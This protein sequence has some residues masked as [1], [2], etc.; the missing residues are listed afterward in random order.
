MNVFVYSGPEVVPLSL[1]HSLTSIRSLLIP[2]YTVQSISLFTLIT[3]PWKTS[4]ALLVMPQLYI[5]KRGFVSAASRHIRDYVEAGGRFMMFGAGASVRSRLGFGPGLTGST[6]GLEEQAQP[7][8]L[9]LTFFNNTDHRYVVFDLSE[10]SLGENIQEG[11]PTVVSL[12][13]EDGTDLKHVY[14]TDSRRLVGF[15]GLGSVSILAR[16]EDSVSCLTM[17]I[18]NGLL[19]LLNPNIEQP[20]NQEPA[21]SILSDVKLSETSRQHFLKR[22]LLK[23]GLDIPDNDT[24]TMASRPLPQFLTCTPRHPMIVSQIVDALSQSRPSSFGDQ[25]LKVLK[26]AEDEFHFHSYHPDE[27]GELLA[28]LRRAETIDQETLNW[29]PKHIVVCSDG[30]LPERKM[31]PLFDFEVY[32]NALH[33]AREQEGLKDDNEEGSWGMGE[34]LLYGEVLT[35]TQTMLTK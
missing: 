15:E 27:S 13:S 1:T 9:P 35:S 7:S 29:Q 21:S 20:L 33:R 30:V 14:K 16:H 6:I 34:A 24:P 32:F 25:A 17:K 18:G 19:A 11:P 31:T 2:H 4:C 26:D 12:V 3:Q 22:V 23:L 8:A 5:S 10:E 28:S